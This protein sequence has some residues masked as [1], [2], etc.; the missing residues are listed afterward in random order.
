M[1]ESIYNIVCHPIVVDTMLSSIYMLYSK[2]CYRFYH[3]LSIL[4]CKLTFS[5]PPSLSR[6]FFSMTTHPSTLPTSRLLLTKQFPQCLPSYSFAVFPVRL[7][8]SRPPLGI[9][10]NSGLV[11]DFFSPCFADAC[12]SGSFGHLICYTSQVSN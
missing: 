7:H 11:L 4:Q 6:F 1:L 8:H 2:T 10:I 5:H 9:L 3:S 12:V